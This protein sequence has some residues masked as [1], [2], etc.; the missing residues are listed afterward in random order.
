MINTYNTLHTSCLL[1]QNNTHPSI[2]HV[3]QTTMPHLLPPPCPSPKADMGR[4]GQQEAPPGRSG[5]QAT[6]CIYTC[7]TLALEDLGGDEYGNC[8]RRLINFNNL[9]FASSLL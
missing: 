6:T 9:P 5:A 3:Y 4:C 7:A 2:K 1:T 8:I